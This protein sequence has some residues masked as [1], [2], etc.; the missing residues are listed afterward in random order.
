MQFCSDLNTLL[1]IQMRNM[2]FYS[3]GL[4]LTLL[5]HKIS[6]MG[7]LKTDGDEISTKAQKP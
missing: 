5:K 2:R 3:A 6:L 1:S 7:G 4:N